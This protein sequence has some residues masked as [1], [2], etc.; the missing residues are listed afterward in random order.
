MNERVE[1]DKRVEFL[2][3][4]ATN[5]KPA[6]LIVVIAVRLRRV[7]R[8]EVLAPCMGRGILER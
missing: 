5:G 4:E 8:T 7:A 6:R 1:R 2:V 3:L